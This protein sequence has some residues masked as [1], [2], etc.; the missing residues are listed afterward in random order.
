M[1]IHLKDKIL[2]SSIRFLNNPFESISLLKEATCMIT[3][4]L[5]SLHLCRLVVTKLFP[6]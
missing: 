1:L 4:E 3:E 5:E 6:M 2:S